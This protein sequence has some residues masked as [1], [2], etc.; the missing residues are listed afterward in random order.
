MDEISFFSSTTAWVRSC[1]ALSFAT[2][3]V[4]V[5][6]RMDFDGQ[7][8]DLI[9]NMLWEKTKGTLHTAG[10]HFRNDAALLTAMTTTTDDRVPQHCLPSFIIRTD[11]SIEPSK[12]P[13]LGKSLGEQEHGFTQ[14]S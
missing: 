2:E 12:W 4:I 13:A 1:A 6:W 11:L 3:D 5:R 7:A 9:A 8:P 10:F 14:P